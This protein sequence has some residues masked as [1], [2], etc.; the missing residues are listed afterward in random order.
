MTSRT[1]SEQVKGILAERWQMSIDEAFGIFRA[2]A[3]AHNRKLSDLARAIADGTQGTDTI[4]VFP[5]RQRKRTADT[6]RVRPPI[7]PAVP[8][9][10]RRLA[11]AWAQWTPARGALVPPWQGVPRRPGSTGSR[12]SG[13]RPCGRDACGGCPGVRPRGSLRAAAGDAF[14]V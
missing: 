1:C 12:R 3:R 11:L 10:D 6:C 14:G 5:S 4:R 7:V 13:G 2:Y 9:G 8:R